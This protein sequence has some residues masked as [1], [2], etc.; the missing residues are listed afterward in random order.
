[1]KLFHCLIRGA[2]LLTGLPLLAW[3][4]TGH[5]IVNELALA[6]LP[7]DF[8]AFVTAPENADRIGFL[9]GEPDRWRNNPDLPIKHY[10]GVDHYLDLEQL[11]W[12]GI[13]PKTAPD[14]RYVFVTEFAQGRAAHADKFPAIDEAKNADH[15]REWPGFLP[16]AVAEYYGKLKSGFSYLKTFETAGGT[17]EEIA[18]AKANIVYIMGV[19][20]HYVGDGAQPLHTTVH[21]NGWEGE[22]PHKYSRWQGIHSW[23]DGG[24]IAKAGITTEMLRSQVTTAQALDVTARD[25]GRDPVFVATMDYII[26]QNGLVEKL[27]MLDQD[28]ELKSANVGKSKVGE[29]FIEGQLLKGGEMLAA[30]WVTAWKNAPFDKYLADQL[31]KRAAATP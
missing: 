19:M 24:F 18:N 14:L 1:M 11:P 6:A 30:I 25:D 29:D 5:R 3:D 12:A 22:N 4:Y 23:I 28:G 27:Y 26:A 17:P 10:N 7:K 15:S 8:P 21:H 31:A 16:W 2:L 20:G 9:A 13:D